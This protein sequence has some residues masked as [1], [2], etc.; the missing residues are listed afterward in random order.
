VEIYWLSIFSGWS[1][2]E[3]WSECTQLYARNRQMIISN[4]WRIHSTRWHDNIIIH[5]RSK[6]SFCRLTYHPHGWHQ[7]WP[8]NKDTKQPRH[9]D[10]GITSDTGLGRH[11]NAFHTAEEF[12]TQQHLEY[13]KRRWHYKITMWLHPWN[14]SKNI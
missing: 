9:R 8:T 5:L 13:G 14:R 6:R 3:T 11:V 7:H 1:T 4:H 10:H 2:T 12:S